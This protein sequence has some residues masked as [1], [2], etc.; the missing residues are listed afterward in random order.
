MAADFLEKYNHVSDSLQHTQLELQ[1]SMARGLLFLISCGTNRAIELKQFFFFY[2]FPFRTSPTLA[3]YG[4]VS[5]PLHE[6]LF[7]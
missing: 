4:G 6:T 3:I 5:S 1:E 2:L 7:S